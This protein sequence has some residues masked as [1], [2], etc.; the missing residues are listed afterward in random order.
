MKDQVFKINLDI[1]VI[2]RLRNKVN[3]QINISYN[4]K[5]GKHRAWDKIRAIMDRLDD[6]VDYLNDLE[7]NTGKYS[8]SAF[9]FFDLMNNASVVVDCIKELAKIFNASYD[10]VKK[11]TNIFNQFGDDGVGRIM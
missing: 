10:K 1:D 7:L 5:Y 6:T 11:A 9:D 4:K 8:R 3:E 2:K